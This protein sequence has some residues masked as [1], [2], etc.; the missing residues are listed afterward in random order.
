[1][2]KSIKTQAA[3]I[4][5]LVGGTSE[6]PHMIDAASVPVVHGKEVAASGNVLQSLAFNVLAG[7]V[8]PEFLEKAAFNESFPR[9]LKNEKSALKFLLDCKAADIR[10]AWEQEQLTRK[11]YAAPTL[12][13]LAK[14]VK[15]MDK[16]PGEMK[17]GVGEQV[18]AILAG[19]GTP[20]AKLDAIA[21][22]E[23]VA[24]YL[25]DASAE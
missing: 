1:M 9:S 21:A 10:A 22:L 7:T 8:A 2:T 20:K 5:V 15:A 17:K 25:G 16:E 6:A 3:E 24:K 23:G 11:R 13:A 18:A 14:A 19:K 4:R 12:Q